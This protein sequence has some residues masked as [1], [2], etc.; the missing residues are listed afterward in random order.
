MSFFNRLPK[1]QQALILI[2]VIG[3]LVVANVVKSL[4]SSPTPSQAFI[5]VPTYTNTPQP[6]L[7]P[8]PTSPPTPDVETLYRRQL[9]ESMLKFQA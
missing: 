1:L 8:R 4:S 9:I 7:T 2:V 5:P 3:F 6:T